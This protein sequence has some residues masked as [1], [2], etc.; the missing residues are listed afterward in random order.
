MTTA[1]KSQ[2]LLA[3][4]LAVA[5]GKGGSGKEAGA[6]VFGNKPVPPGEL[7]KVKAGMTQAEVKNVFPSA[8]PTPN[9]SGSPSLSLDSGYSNLEYRIG[10]Y[11]D[12]DAVADI[13]VIA[14]KSLDLVT[15][16]Q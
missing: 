7:I 6:E 13:E 16:L 11:S 3:A 15:K 9:H 5:C 10:F 12:K 1:R 8:K 14:P 4:L 2:T